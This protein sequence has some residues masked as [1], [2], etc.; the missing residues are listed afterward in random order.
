MSSLTVGPNRAHH[1]VAEGETTNILSNFSTDFIY[2]VTTDLLQERFREFNLI[3]KVNFID[4][5]EATF[6]DLLK[7]YPYDE[8]NI[9]MTRQNVY[10]QIINI[11]SQYTGVTIYNDDNTDIY[12]LAR[13]IFDLFI[14]SYDRCVFTFLYNFIYEQK[15]ALY[16]A[17]DL[18]KN[19]KS[20]DIS[21]IYNRQNYN[22]FTMAIINANLDKVLDFIAG[23]DIPAYDILKRI[24]CSSDNVHTLNF[25]NNHL[26]MSC[27]LFNIMIRPVL[28]NPILYPVLSTSI[29]LEIQ[30]NSVNIVSSFTPID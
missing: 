24:Y 5:L 3:P 22:D 19:K 20:K 12:N 10:T 18:E 2:N 27:P 23:V 11:I 17:L 29:K 4:N 8:Y 30:K 25:L 14:S 6:K 15:D 13:C 1:L 28:T 26:D 21:T 9:K 16:R 7:N